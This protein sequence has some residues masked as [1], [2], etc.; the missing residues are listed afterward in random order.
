MRILMLS[1]RYLGHP[2]AGGAETLTHEM[3][4]RCAAAGWEVTAFT[5]M[6]PGAAPVEDV[7][8]VTV[9]RRGEQHTV[10]LHAWRWL[11]GRLSQF[12]RVVDQVNTIAFNTPLYVPAE[13]RRLL[14][15]QF[16]RE[17]WFRETRGAFRL[18]A[19]LGYALEP[20]Q[21]RLYRTTP[22]ITISDSTRRELEAV[23]IPVVGVLPMAFHARPVSALAPKAGPLR[24]VVVGRLTPAKFLEEA[25]DVFT[26]VQDAVPEAALD[27]VGDGDAAYRQRLE[28]TVAERGLRGVTFH[29]RVT[30]ERKAELLEQAHQHVFTSHREGWG[31]TVSEAAAAGTPTLAYDAPGV[32]DS[33]RDSRLLAPIGDTAA[34]ARRSVE[35]GTDPRLYTAVREEAWARARNL[36]WDA[37]AL[38]FMDLVT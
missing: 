18:I 34:L 37:T 22:A 27:I 24:L 30:E 38:R 20:L 19:P 2:Q 6:Y 31:L 36:S 17:Y 28:A 25:L 5:A 10:H 11:R 1:W 26:R 35:L 12:D 8:G 3:L 16:A 23:G 9:L 21:A 13:L 7:D 4:K 32:R 29:G 33:V 14:I 15:H